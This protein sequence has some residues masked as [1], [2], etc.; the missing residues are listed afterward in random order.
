MD[1]ELDLGDAP[2]ALRAFPLAVATQVELAQRGAQVAQE[3]GIHPVGIQCLEIGEFELR[4]AHTAAVHA[5]GREHFVTRVTAAW[6]DVW[7]F[8]LSGVCA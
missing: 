8:P 7:P 4:P 6:P 3:L 1:S 5:L 2:A